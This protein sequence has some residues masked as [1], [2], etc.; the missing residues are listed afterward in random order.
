MTKKKDAL[1]TLIQ[2]L[3][4]SEKRYFKLYA[5]GNGQQPNNKYIKLFD[6]VNHPRGYNE[7]ALQKKL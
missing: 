6:A 2:H 7:A 1:S 5:K 4:P 3:T